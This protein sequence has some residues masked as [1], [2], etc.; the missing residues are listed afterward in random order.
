MSTTATDEQG[1]S[2]AWPMLNTQQAEAIV[3]VLEAAPAVRRRYQYFV[4]TQSQL[5]MLLPHQILVCGAYLRQR[6][7]LV[8]EAF[9]SIV[10]PPDLLDLLTDT[11]GPLLRSLLA[12]WVDGRGQ[13]LLMSPSR[14]AGPG[15][16]D[17]LAVLQTSRIESLLMH[18]V[19]RP[20][21][22]AEIESFFVFAS[23][24]AMAPHP[25]LTHIE[26]LLPH[27]HWSWQRVM[28]AEREMALPTPAAKTVARSP[29]ATPARRITE[30]ERQVLLWVRE[31]KSNQEIGEAL[32]IS[33]LTVKN[34]VQ[35]I[36]RKL[37]CS[38]RAQA[39]A[40]AMALGL[41]PAGG[42]R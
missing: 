28:A 29:G 17:T 14:L 9:H 16:I 15:L 13:P 5:Q 12:A 39:V 30:R 41:L 36:L 18:G 21:R 37:E 6:R 24:D 8:F 38:N 11:Q 34:H 1:G 20:Q 35:K 4:W 42:A 23:P 33:P 26:L 31:G 3:R 2:S 7:D 19:S 25:A 22:P 32:G 27:L 10:L 40:D